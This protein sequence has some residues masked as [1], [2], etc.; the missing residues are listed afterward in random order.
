MSNI[1]YYERF[2][3]ETIYLWNDEA[4]VYVK[5]VPG[6][7]Y[8]AKYKKGEEFPVVASSDLVVMAIDSKQEVSRSTYEKA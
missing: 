6:V 5:S 1:S 4:Q 8:F 7:G 3:K 2:K